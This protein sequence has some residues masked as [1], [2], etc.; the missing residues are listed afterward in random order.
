M[1]AVIWI[2]VIRY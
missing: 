1:P 2:P